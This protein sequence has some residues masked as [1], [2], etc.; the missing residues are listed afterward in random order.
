MEVQ[1]LEHE[2]DPWGADWD[3]APGGIYGQDGVRV[4]N[5]RS[6]ELQVADGIRELQKNKEPNLIILWMDFYCLICDR[7]ALIFPLFFLI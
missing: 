4:D 6:G 7:Q 1:Q 2:S 5:A 3:G